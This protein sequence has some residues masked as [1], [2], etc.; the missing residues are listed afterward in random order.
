MKKEIAND[1]KAIKL[2]VD[3]RNY[4]EETC[5][6]MQKDYEFEINK[7]RKETARETL[8]ELKIK[9]NGQ[10]DDVDEYYSFDVEEFIDDIAKEYG[11]EV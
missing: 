4:F 1:V 5:N 10:F 3:E 8:Q 6:V 2:L 7:V 9:Y 11:I